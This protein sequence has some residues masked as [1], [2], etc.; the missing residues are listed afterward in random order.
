MSIKLFPTILIILMA[1]SAIVYGFNGDIKHTLYWS[2]AV[3]L[4]YAVT[5]ME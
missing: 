3:I 4:N 5:Y 1:L 2:G